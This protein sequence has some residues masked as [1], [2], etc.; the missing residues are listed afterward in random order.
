MTISEAKERLDY[1]LNQSASAVEDK[2][3]DDDIIPATPKRKSLNDHPP[4]YSSQSDHKQLQ[5][6]F[7]KRLFHEPVMNLKSKLQKRHDSV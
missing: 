2:D 3:S 4:G 7:E 1:Y 6:A 5:N